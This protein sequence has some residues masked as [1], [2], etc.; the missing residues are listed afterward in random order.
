MESA[1]YCRSQFQWGNNATFTLHGMQ[2]ASV[3]VFNGV[4]F[5]DEFY[6]ISDFILALAA[7]V[8][9]KVEPVEF[10]APQF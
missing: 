7:Q 9:V 8:S 3:A 1:N 6:S 5:M 10:C 4:A 2:E